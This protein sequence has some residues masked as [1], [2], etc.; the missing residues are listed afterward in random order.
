MNVDDPPPP[1]PPVTTTPFTF[2]CA[3]GKLVGS[4]LMTLPLAST[5]TS[6]NCAAQASGSK[7]SNA[8][9]RLTIPILSLEYMGLW[10]NY[11]Y[12]VGLFRLRRLF[13]ASRR[14]EL[15]PMY[16]RR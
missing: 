15:F 1:P 13:R 14:S 4:E 6:A 3:V 7:H 2:S 11:S 12:P 5:F 10:L 9:N 8:I 16:S